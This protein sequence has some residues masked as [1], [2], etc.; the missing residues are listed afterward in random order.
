MTTTDPSAT[1]VPIAHHG[2]DR[3]FAHS[4]IPAT[5]EIAKAIAGATYSVPSG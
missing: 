4:A 1:T 2:A 5:I 3:R